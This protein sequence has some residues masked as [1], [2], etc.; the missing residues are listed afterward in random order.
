MTSSEIVT[1]DFT[2]RYDRARQFFPETD[3]VLY[4]EANAKTCTGCPDTTCS[5][6]NGMPFA[7]T[8]DPM[9]MNNNSITK[10]PDFVM[11]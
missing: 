3:H 7:M 2:L 10:E 4:K 11:I 9:T 6:E 1:V 8:M 5:T